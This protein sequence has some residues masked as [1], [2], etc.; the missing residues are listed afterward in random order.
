[1]STSTEPR[2]AARELPDVDAEREVDLRGHWNALALRWWLP[3]AGLVAGIAIGFLVALGGSQV[4]TAK[5]TVY[6]GQPLSPGGSAQIQSQATNPSTVRAIIRGEAALRDA[7]RAAGMHVSKLRGHVSSQA[8]SGALTKL[9]Q[10]PL[11]RITVTGSPPRKIGIA[12][13]TLAKIVIKDTSGYVATK[14]ATLKSQLDSYS[15]SLSSIDSTIDGLRRAASSAATDRGLVLAIELSSLT[16]QR[17]QIVE[18]Q[19]TARQLLSV[20]QTV[21]RGQLIGRAVPTKTTARSRRNSVIVAGLIGLL[22][23]IF[24]A[25]LWEPAGRI[26][27]RPA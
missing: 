6:L 20:A 7:A 11:V 14:I 12:A 4:Y 8:V 22:L 9:G 13:N 17:S 2:P 23:G 15:Q 25:L 18:S 16:V 1:M 24:A 21:E 26:V 19:A 3:A 10:T 5:A 27:R